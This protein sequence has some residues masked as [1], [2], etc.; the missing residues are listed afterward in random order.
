MAY[1][2]WIEVTVYSESMKLQVKSAILPWGKFHKKGHKGTEISKADIN[3]IQIPSGSSATIC[4]C[5]RSNAASGT[6]GSFKLYDGSTL[7]GVFSWNCP[8][9]SKSNSY[10]WKPEDNSNYQN[11]SEGG[12]KDSGAIGN[13]SITCIKIGG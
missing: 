4:S 10:K 12:N 8:W 6:Q 13:I 1:A 2:Q 9:G 7:V 11:S 3:K 5:G